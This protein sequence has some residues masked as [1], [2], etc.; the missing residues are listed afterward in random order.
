MKNYLWCWL[1]LFKL[2][3]VEHLHSNSV[4]V[5]IFYEK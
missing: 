4:K 5:L 1:F 2:E 3:I